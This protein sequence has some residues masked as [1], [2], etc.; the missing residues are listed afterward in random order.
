MGSNHV[1]IAIAFLLLSLAQ[2]A[3]PRDPKPAPRES[4]PGAVIAG[5]VVDAET[6]APIAGAVV[7][8]S[9]MRSTERPKPV[10]TDGQGNFRMAGLAAGDYRVSVNP[11]EYKAT[12]LA[13]T[14]NAE[15]GVLPARPSVQLKA[16]EVR[17]DIV[18]RLDRALAIEGRVLDELGR[19]MSDVQV[20]A[21]RVD[22]PGIIGFQQYTDDRGLFRIYNMTAGSYRVCATPA[23]SPSDYRIGRATSGEPVERPY[24]RTC[25]QPVALKHGIVPQ[26]AI[27]IQQVNGFA[28]S[29]RVLSESGRRRI[30]VS[31]QTLD[32]VGGQSIPVTAKGNVFYAH[33]VPPGDYALRA[34]AMLDQVAPN[35]PADVERGTVLIRVDG[36]V[37]DLE[38]T[39][40][41]GAI[42]AGRIVPEVPLPPGTRLYVARGGTYNRMFGAYTAST[43]RAD[44]NFE[45]KDVHDPMLLDVIGLPRDWVVM[46][47]RYRGKNVVDSMTQFA[48][49]TDASELEIAVTPRSALLTVRPVDAEGRLLERVRIAMIRTSGDRVAILPRG[50]AEILPEGGIQMG[51]APPGEYAV[52]VFRLDAPVP[53]GAEYAETI[54]RLGTRIVLEP[55]R[56]TIDVVVTS[57][58]EVR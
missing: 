49:T 34:S 12:H 28:V 46:S 31:L 33:G 2:Q 8:I 54:R 35:T 19:P 3:Q 38:V 52:L 14:L 48:S 11:P 9:L 27:T 15:P 39:T 20:G 43:P 51:A 45:L 37:P 13:K 16:R 57:L 1:V 5:R 26:V 53:R 56:R 10:E 18:I 58:P 55:G 23:A 50:D 32:D 44:L 42:L 41:K 25:G 7:Y 47:V 30:S 21:E 6:Q 24:I 17:E 36:P 29:G 22:R 4:A 40:K